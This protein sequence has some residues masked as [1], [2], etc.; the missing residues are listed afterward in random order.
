MKYLTILFVAIGGWLSAAD[1]RPNV[2]LIMSDDQGW[3][4]TGYN[5]HPHLKTPHLDEMAANGL[6]LDRFY[7]GASNCSPTRATVLTG[8][9]NDRTGVQNHGYPLRLQEKTIAGALRDHGYTTAHFGK[10]HLNGLRGPGV[11]VLKEDTHS[12][13]AFGFDH[14]LTVTNYFDR[15]PILSRMGEFEEFEGDSSEVVIGE[16]LK[17]I[18]KQQNSNK[19]VFVVVWYGSPHSPMIADEDD[20]SQFANLKSDTGNHLGE[21]VAMDR[22]IGTLRSGLRD[23]GIADDTLV[24]FNSDNGGLKNYGP[25]TVGGLRGHKNQ[26]YEGGLRVPCLIEWPKVINPGRQSYFPAGTVD[27]FPT[28]AAITGL[29]PDTVMIKPY[30]GISLF[31]LFKKDVVARQKPLGFR[32]D[33]RGVLIDYPFKYIIQNGKEEMYHLNEDKSESKNLVA[34][35]PKIA[36][37][38][39]KEYN[40][41]NA[42]VEASVLGKDYPEG[43]VDSNQPERR[44]WNT[45]P[46]YEEHLDAWKDR[47]EYRRWVKKRQNP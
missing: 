17:F 14:W 46:A 12:P 28:I 40:K 15:N 5:G 8:R 43:A 30:D 13:G 7:A 24:W 36:A 42:G 41:W 4:Q 6:R 10:W 44:F 29:D 21:L 47:P 19:P 23:L 3:G 45:D 9:T 32:H 34:T 39:R 26:M 31:E 18:E 22:S 27:I 25:E 16:A 11:P 33:G 37:R 38:L 35:K 1:S 2:V 20:R